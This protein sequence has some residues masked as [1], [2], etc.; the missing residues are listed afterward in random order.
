MSNSEQ[1]SEPTISGE[2]QRTA[3]PSIGQNQDLPSSSYEQTP[4]TSQFGTTPSQSSNMNM[5]MF[6][7]MMGAPWCPKFKGGQESEHGFQDWRT[8]QTTMFDMYPLSE[9]QKVSSLINNLEGEARREVLALPVAQRATVQTILSFLEGIYGDTTPLA[10]LRS[11]F[12]TRKQRAEENVRQFALVLQELSNRLTARGD[13]TTEGH[14]LRDQFISGLLDGGLRRELRGMVRA[15]VNL[16]FADIKREAMLRVEDLE[17]TTHA[18]AA[19]VQIKQDRVS[20]RVPIDA[21]QLA[22]EI[23]EE[24]LSKLKGEMK[25]MLSGMMREVREGTQMSQQADVRPRYEFRGG[26]RSSDQFDQQGR[27]ICR[28]CKKVGHIER[29][30]R[31]QEGAPE[32]LNE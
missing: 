19:A 7:V 31:A 30:C 22:E 8:A 3:Q 12:F 9:A 14:I 18:M 21:K 28:R 13:K 25:E 17:N 24:V 29:R 11:K 23:K 15:S 32:H 10:S 6:P 5:V 4:R 27:P 1:V 16:S 26:R 2:T 20:P